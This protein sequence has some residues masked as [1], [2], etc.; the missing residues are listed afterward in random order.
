MELLTKTES[1]SFRASEE[2]SVFPVVLSA[3]AMKPIEKIY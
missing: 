2:S 3:V 1:A